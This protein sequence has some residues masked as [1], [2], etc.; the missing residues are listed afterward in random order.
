MHFRHPRTILLTI[1]LLFIG[2]CSSATDNK[3]A[4]KTWLD[5]EE[6]SLQIHRDHEPTETEEAK[7][8]P[9]QPEASETKT[10][11]IRNMS[12]APGTGNPLLTSAAK[13][14]EQQR[15]D[16]PSA[17][18]GEGVLL[19]FDNA[20]IYEVIQVISEILNLD[21]IIDPQVKG[22]V[23]IRSG[24]KI[25]IEQLFAVF[26]KIL[27][28]NG[29]DIRQEGEYDYIFA[30]N[31][32]TA[33]I[34]YS[35]EQI[36][37]LKDSPRI[38]MQ[39]VPIMHLSSAEAIKL[40]KP[41]LSERG[42]VENLSSMNTI[43]IC[44][45][46]S[47]IIDVLTILA[48][49]DISPLSALKI[50]LVKVEKAPLFDLRDELIEILSAMQI[51]Q[52]DYQGVTALPL[53]R[54]NSMLLVSNNEQLLDSATLWLTEL[55]I[56]PEEGRDN[57]Y[58]YNVRN[59][60]ASELA[61]LVT[62][63]LSENGAGNKPA[64]AKKAVTRRSS[65]TNTSATTPA[66]APAS[67]PPSPIRS[68]TSA[69]ESSMRFTGEP[70]LIADDSR[71]VIILRALPTDYNRLVKLLERLDNMPRQVLIE[72]LVAEVTLSNDWE[73][74]VE[75]SMNDQ[76]LKI[77][78]SSYTNNYTS[79]LSQIGNGADITHSNLLT[80][81]SG[82]TYSVLNSTGEAIGILNSIASDNDLSILSSPQIM[83]LNNES[84]MVKVGQEVPITTTQ[85]VS[86]DPNV[87]DVRT[88]QYRDTGVIL[89]VSPRI[90]YNG[91]II[92]DVEQTVSEAQ[93]QNTTSDIKSPIIITRELKTKLAVKDGQ[94]I[95][96]GGMLSNKTDSGESGIPLLKDI[97]LLGWLF[98]SKSETTRKTEL[99]VMITPYVIESEDVLD[100]YAQRFKEKVTD[101][102]TKLQKTN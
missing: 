82:F 57:I 98:K 9:D 32:P 4:T 74:G 37:L 85:T 15:E 73:F 87:N 64:V 7:E 20:D 76:R 27:N 95:L 44:D 8:L 10:T 45:F 79:N 50:R 71:N 11:K 67:P 56:L 88:V 60:V 77:N 19:N 59:S 80:T 90:N 55:D 97:P 83:V 65:S 1:L 6:I 14:K 68:N 25:P 42:S 35:P 75:W 51:N 13:Q 91:M 17:S 5:L 33:Q 49:L 63:L 89:H 16:T 29:L 102:K 86:D 92:V 61:A 41:Y 70:M 48:Q 101:L 3:V 18:R 36:R 54:I 34:I 58:I 96:M 81:A 26:K 28:I 52:K 22:V 38:V 23:N 66:A 21:Y 43:F 53:E 93:E 72:V 78:N 39:V 84:A 62:D 47:K 24:N 69:P 94:S 46:E 2:S 30:A 100:Q 99:L 12:A 31:K 40:I